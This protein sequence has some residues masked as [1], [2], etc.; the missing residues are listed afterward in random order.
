MSFLWRLF[1]RSYNRFRPKV[2]YGILPPCYRCVYTKSHE[3]ILII[4]KDRGVRII[5]NLN[6][7]TYIRKGKCLGYSACGSCF[8]RIMEDLDLPCEWI[9][10]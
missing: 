8:K 2:T 9:E 10:I 6:G 7:K 3:A 4:S 5:V 1:R